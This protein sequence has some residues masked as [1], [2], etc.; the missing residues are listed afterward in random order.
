MPLLR[1]IES[2]IGSAALA[3][4]AA[5]GP[6]GFIELPGEDLVFDVSF[7]KMEPGNT[8]NFVGGGP[9]GCCCKAETKLKHGVCGRSWTL[10]DD[11]TISP[12][13]RADLVLGRG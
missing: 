9:Q 4:S 10:N 6:D 11:G 13:K 5:Y 12:L 3:V 8:V 1:Y 2:G 7:W